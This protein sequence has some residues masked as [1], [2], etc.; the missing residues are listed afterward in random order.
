MH[1]FHL[2][3][4]AH[5]AGSIQ[6]DSPQQL[7]SSGSEAT[8]PASALPSTYGVKCVSGSPCLVDRIDFYGVT[9]GAVAW[10]H[11]GSK[12]EDKRLG[13]RSTRRTAPSAPPLV[14]SSTSNWPKS[15]RRLGKW[16]QHNILFKIWGRTF[17]PNDWQ[18]LHC[19]D[20]PRRL[21]S[22][23]EGGNASLIPN[24]FSI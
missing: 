3:H 21:N 7:G 16:R 22:R 24:I 9:T 13:G 6:V 5:G 14:T 8:T 15:Y 17:A 1:P 10:R 18:R 23:S 20:R 4:H 2:Q 19:L 12:Q 11:E